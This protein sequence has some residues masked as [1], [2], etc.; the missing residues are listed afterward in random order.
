ML[1]SLD[2][3]LEKYDGFET[4]YVKVLYYDLP[5]NYDGIYQTNSYSRF[6][7]ILEGEKHIKV[8]NQSFTYGTE[9][10]LLLPPH[11]S[12]SMK[13]NSPT[14]ALVFE[15]NDTL[16]QDVI[17]KAGIDFERTHQ[18]HSPK[19]ILIDGIERNIKE[20]VANLVKI[21]QSKFQKSQFLVDLYA[22]HLIY[23][24]LQHQS[25]M[26]II[27]YQKRHPL[28]QVITYIEKH[29]DENINVN[30]LAEK[31]GMSDSNFSHTFKKYIGMTPQ[32][33]LQRS[34]MLYAEELL[35]IRSVT[36]VAYELGYENISHFIRV[37]KQHSGMTPKQYQLQKRRFN[38]AYKNH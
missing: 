29:I 28:N 21:D 24:L 30:Q 36:D 6:C 5:A 8:R 7:T 13:I 12:V 4:D 32:K 26:G 18:I 25:A 15:L 10:S 22:Q 35:L 31:F 27:S 37:F 2:A 9:Q 23:D 14:K 3:H 34:K 16:I 11:A 19:E 17:N 1:H 33:Y 38:A 20:D